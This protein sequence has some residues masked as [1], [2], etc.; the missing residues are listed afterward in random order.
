MSYSYDIEMFAP[1]STPTHCTD[2]D[3]GATDGRLWDCTT[4][5][6]F[7]SICGAYDDNDFS[8][9]A[10]CCACG[11]AATPSP[12][13]P[14]REKASADQNTFGYQIGGSIAGFALIV[15]LLFCVKCVTRLIPT[16]RA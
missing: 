9:T 4:Y 3:N 6:S 12:V 1:S 13:T 15:V 10:M 7:P 14:P 16:S 11:S 8:S 5:S 2:T